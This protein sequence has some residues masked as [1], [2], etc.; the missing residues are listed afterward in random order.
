MQ[1]D[2]RGLI[3]AH[4]GDISQ[5]P[6]FLRAYGASR[7]PSTEQIRKWKS[8]GVPGGYLVDIMAYIEIET[9]RPVSL[10]P[11]IVGIA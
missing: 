7:V 9:G 4:I 10:A 2:G 3:E 5:V 1:V 11:Y 6:A 8:R